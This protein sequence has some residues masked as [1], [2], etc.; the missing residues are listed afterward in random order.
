LE[1]RNGEGGSLSCAGL[2]LCDNIMTLHHGD[3]STLLNGGRPL[4]TA[5]LSKKV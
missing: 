5:V 2:G 1:N 3:D 4:K